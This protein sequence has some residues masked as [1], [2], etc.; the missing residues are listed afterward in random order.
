MNAPGSTCHE[1]ATREHG[2][3]TLEF[4]MLL[5]ALLFAIMLVFQMGLAFH[6]KSVAEQAA[7]EGA[8]AARRFDGTAGQAKAK[9]QGF[10]AQTA[11]KIIETPT[12]TVSRTGAEASVT[13]TGTVVSIVPGVK[14]KVAET[15]GGPVERY[16]PPE[17]NP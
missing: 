4:V 6:A 8:A 2:A 9:A 12:V 7:Q 14:M 15:A 3:A 16:V 17:N 13:I 11:S 10:L 5:P 1:R